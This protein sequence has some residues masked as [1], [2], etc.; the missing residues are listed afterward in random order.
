M[1]KQPIKYFEGVGR[2]KTAT[3]RVRITP[4]KKDQ[5][6]SILVNQKAIETYWPGEYHAKLYLEP[7]RTTNTLEQFQTTV[8][9]SG[10]GKSAQLQAFILGASRALVKFDQERFRLILKK[11][12]FLTRDSRAK[13]RR[14]PGLAQ[15]ARAAKQSPKR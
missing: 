2:R 14:K 5:K 13:E 9:I 6:P 7:F 15:S 4:I 10:A 11:R 1:T 8:K 3:A 12:G